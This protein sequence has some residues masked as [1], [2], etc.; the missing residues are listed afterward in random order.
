MNRYF[1]RILLISSLAISFLSVGCSQ[2]N[3][4]QASN[5]ASGDPLAKTLPVANSIAPNNQ[6]K[7]TV[8]QKSKPSDTL[9]AK[10]NNVVYEKLSGYV[11]DFNK[12]RN[13]ECLV[14]NGVPLF[15]KIRNAE[16]EYGNH[17]G[18]YYLEN[19]KQTDVGDSFASSPSL[20]KDLLPFLKK[21]A[22]SLRVT[23]VLIQ[24]SDEIETFRSPYATKVEGLD[25][26]GQV[27]WTVTGK[28]P[29]K[30]KFPV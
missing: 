8:K 10:S 6:V 27:L 20:A 30:L 26:N 21:D 7:T 15:S 16:D 12:R 1:N 25:E 2:A 28:P 13:G 5:S 18:L 29:A 24:F 4:A 17:K 23:A 3:R 14:V 19:D 22:K 9:C 11:N